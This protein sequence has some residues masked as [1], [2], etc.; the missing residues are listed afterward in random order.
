MRVIIYVWCMPIYM[1]P[2][3]GEKQVVGSSAGR[4]WGGIRIPNTHNFW[5]GGLG[6][7]RI[8]EAVELIRELPGWLFVQRDRK[9]PLESGRPTWGSDGPGL[10][11]WVATSETGWHRRPPP[12]P[13]PPFPSLLLSQPQVTATRRKINTTALDRLAS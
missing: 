13:L 9:Y 5:G 2:Y 12:P 11:I 4:L 6:R 1:G 3:P 10:T 7:V 8:C